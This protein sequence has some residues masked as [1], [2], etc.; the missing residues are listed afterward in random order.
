MLGPHVASWRGSE[1]H[2]L[3]TSDR[4]DRFLLSYLTFLSRD[5]KETLKRSTLAA[6]GL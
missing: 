5:F 3:E 1:P 6:V 2:G 4:E